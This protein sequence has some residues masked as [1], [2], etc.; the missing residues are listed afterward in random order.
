MADRTSQPQVREYLRVKGKLTDLRDQ[1][2]GYQKSAGHGCGQWQPSAEE[3]RAPSSG[4]RP[5]RS[6]QVVVAF[7]LPTWL[8]ADLGQPCHCHHTI[9]AG[10]EGPGWVEVA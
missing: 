3:D 1:P 2:C 5:C 6:F 9:T 8:W 4:I 10:L 7:L